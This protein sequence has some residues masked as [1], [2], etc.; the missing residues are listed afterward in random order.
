MVS[1]FKFSYQNFVLVNRYMRAT[2]PAHLTYIVIDT[3]NSICCE[4]LIMS[5]LIIQRNFT[6]C[7]ESRCFLIL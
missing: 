1:Y 3:A 6:E 5:L 4:A 2:R 7:K